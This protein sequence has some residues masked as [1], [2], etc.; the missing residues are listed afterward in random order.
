MELIQPIPLVLLKSL[1]N[2]IHMK[3]INNNGDKI[4]TL[5]VI[6]NKMTIINSLKIF[7]TIHWEFNSTKFQRD[8]KS[9]M[10]MDILLKK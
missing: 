4:S 7:N 5:K 6:N 3:K 8:M 1:I 2:R 10:E 9:F